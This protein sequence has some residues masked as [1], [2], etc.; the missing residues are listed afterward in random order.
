MTT[1]AQTVSTPITISQPVRTGSLVCAKTGARHDSNDIGMVLAK[2][3]DECEVM[4]QSDSSR[5]KIKA[6]TIKLWDANPN[7]T[8]S[9]VKTDDKDGDNHVKFK[10]L[11]P[12]KVPTDLVCPL[13][14]QDLLKI[15]TFQLRADSLLTSGH[16]NVN[17][18]IIGEIDNPLQYFD[19]VINLLKLQSAPAPFTFDPRKMSHYIYRASPVTSAR[20]NATRG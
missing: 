11:I 13:H 3:G 14:S 20:I 15:Q 17:K 12:T 10:E 18:V 16:P 6:D 2:S 7:N 9:P 4:W 19:E 5:E 8:P 1:T